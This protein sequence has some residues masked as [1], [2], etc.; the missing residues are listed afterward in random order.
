M[1]KSEKPKMRDIKPQGLTLSQTDA[2][3]EK[4]PTLNK[5]ALASP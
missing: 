1:E 3:S 2:I 4:L 5:F